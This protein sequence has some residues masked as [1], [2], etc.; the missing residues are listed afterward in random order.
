MSVIEYPQ[1]RVFYDDDR[2]ITQGFCPYEL[3][4]RERIKKV[5]LISDG[6]VIIGANVPKDKTLIIRRRN[7]LE[8][9][10][11]WSGST[12]W[13]IIGFLEGIDEDGSQRGEFWLADSRGRI[14]LCTKLKDGEEIAYPVQ[15]IPSEERDLQRHLKG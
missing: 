9:A 15:L 8:S 10:P 2:V 7:R 1:W 12:F 4:E 5:E 11:D 3:L 13:Y 14:T 6:Q